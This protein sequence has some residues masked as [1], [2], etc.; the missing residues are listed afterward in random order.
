MF[1]EHS[2]MR[3][4][5]SYEKVRQDLGAILDPVEL[6][7]R[8]LPEEEAFAMRYKVQVRLHRIVCDIAVWHKRV[9]IPH[10]KSFFLRKCSV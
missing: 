10:G 4:K 7:I 9:Q 3:I 1:L 2:R 5:E 8:T 6:V